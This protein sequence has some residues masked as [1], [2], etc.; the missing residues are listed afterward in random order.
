MNAP[1]GRADSLTASSWTNLDGPLSFTGPGKGEL[2]AILLHMPGVLVLNLV[3]TTYSQVDTLTRYVHTAL[4]S[5]I[6][7][8]TTE[9]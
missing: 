3:G 2:S 9:I 8:T 5:R 1:S 6:E 4:S 7:N